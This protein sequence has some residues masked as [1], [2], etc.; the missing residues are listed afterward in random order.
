MAAIKELR[1]S[2]GAPSV[3]R[4]PLA[5]DVTWVAAGLAMLVAGTGHLTFARRG[6][7]A[8]VP[9]WVHGHKDTMVL[10]SSVVEI[11][12]GAAVIGLPRYRESLGTVLAAFLVAVYPGSISQYTGRRDGL[13]LDTDRK[14]A[15][16]LAFQPLII[17]TARWSTRDQASP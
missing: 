7:Q 14:R 8:Q 15:I 1:P 13:G 3:R 16:R 6:F 11:A 5:R 9:D 4:R 17:A 12:M 10:A 2:T